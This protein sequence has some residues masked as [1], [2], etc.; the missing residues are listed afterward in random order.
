M[1]GHLAVPALDA[2]PAPMV[3][4]AKRDNRYAVDANEAPANATLPATI[5]ASNQQNNRQTRL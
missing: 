5:S 3:A 1:M 4:A 2:T